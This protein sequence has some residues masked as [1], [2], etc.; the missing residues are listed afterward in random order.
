M[1]PPMLWAVRIGILGGTFDPPHLAHLLAGETAYRQLL[2]D[3]V[4][5]IPAGAPWQKA[6]NNVTEASHRWAMTVL[7]T[8]GVD[9]FVPDDRE[10]VRDGW[11]YTIDTLEEFGAHDELFLVLG[12]D[13][14]R[15]LP[16]WH[17]ADEVVARARLVV[18]PRPGVE[19]HEVEEA[20]KVT[21][22]LDMPLLGISGTDVRER[23]RQHKSYRF[24]VRDNV[25]SYLQDQGVK[26]EVEA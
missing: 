16:S 2:L 6:R 25:W 3:E 17:R 21:H 5:F 4:R 12:A 11:T 9:Y 22:W 13:A 20:V 1:N 10:V 26:F 15:N 23:A 24:L 18:A 8:E 19:R 7:A 14:A